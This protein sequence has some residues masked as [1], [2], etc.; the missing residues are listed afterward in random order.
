MASDKIRKLVFIRVDGGSNSSSSAAP[1]KA[2]VP[3]VEGSDFDQFLGR[4]RRRLGLPEGTSIE[5]LDTAT[6]TVSSMERLIE[7]SSSSSGRDGFFFPVSEFVCSSPMCM[8][9]FS[10]RVLFSL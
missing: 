8:K 5:L 3:L 10:H 2:V 9:P 7:V 6:G 4:V 1:R